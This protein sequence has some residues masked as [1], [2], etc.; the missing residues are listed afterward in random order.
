MPYTQTERLA[1]DRANVLTTL[2]LTNGKISGED[3]AAALLGIRPTTLASCMKALG[4]DKEKSGKSYCEDYPPT[5]NYMPC[6]CSIDKSC[7]TI[8]I[9]GAERLIERLRMYQLGVQ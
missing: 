6:F 2:S 1:R 4:V 9:V 5:F 8:R 3:G 7:D